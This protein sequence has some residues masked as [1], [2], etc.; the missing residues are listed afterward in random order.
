VRATRLLLIAGLLAGPAPAGAAPAALPLLRLAQSG[1]ASSDAYTWALEL[2][3]VNPLETGLYLD[4][5][6]LEVDDLDPGE[7]RA[8]RRTRVDLSFLLHLT[9][10]LAAGDSTSLRFEANAVAERAHLTFTLHAR[11]A[12]GGAYVSSATLDAE[13]G[14]AWRRVAPE[15]LTVG[16]RRV[17]IAFLPAEG[18]EGAAPGMLIVH[19]HASHAR[20][21]VPIAHALARSGIAAMLVSMPG[22]GR[23]EGP[24]DLCGP[25]TVR[26]A[27]AA[28]DALARRSGVDSTRLGAWGLSRGAGVVASLATRRAD[29]RAAVVQSGI[30]D[31]W[32]VHRGTTLAGFPE[33]IVAE[34]GTDSAAWRAR[35]PILAARRIHAALLVL[36]GE[37]DPNVPAG[38]AHAFVEAVR[39]AGGSVESHFFPNARH[40]LPRGER[41]RLL[42]DF[43]QRRLV[44]R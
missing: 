23:S 42:S 36:H 2:P 10:S 18:V 21:T 39:Q 34:A 3:I 35:S 4:S 26:A 12:Q 37:R 20:L 13:P 33:A 28:L 9:P 32:A 8:A 1:V 43:L 41:D 25:A 16:G 17:E 22:Y 31:L 7:T 6:A 27:E 38:Q 30:Y 29:L 40:A 19:G 15:S 11:D 44:D 24:A 5:L 14:E